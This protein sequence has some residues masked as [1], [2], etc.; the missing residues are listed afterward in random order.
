MKRPSGDQ[1]S[2]VLLSGVSRSGR[3]SLPSLAADFWYRSY[4]PF[5]FELNT[6]LPPSGD[7]MAPVSFAGSRVN[8]LSKL[9]LSSSSQTSIFPSTVRFIATWLPSGESDEFPQKYG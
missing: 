9:R 5:R 8:R 3:S 4:A 7:Q 6:M 2:A 1:S